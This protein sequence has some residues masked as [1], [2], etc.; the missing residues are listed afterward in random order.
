MAGA[1]AADSKTGLVHASGALAGMAGRWPRQGLHISTVACFLT[2]Q[3]RVPENKM[4]GLLWQALEV[5]WRYVCHTL[6]IESQA[7]PD[8]RRGNTGSAS[9]WGNVKEFVAVL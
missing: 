8:A 6:L 2:W 4:H 9:W 1:G 3:H 7:H 5:A